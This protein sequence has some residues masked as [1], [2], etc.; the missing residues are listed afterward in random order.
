MENSRPESIKIPVDVATNYKLVRQRDNLS[1]MGVIK[2]V[3]WNKD[4]G[5]KALHEKPEV[6][7]SCIVNPN[8]ISYTWLT[9][10][11]TEL[12]SETEFRTENSHYKIE[13]IDES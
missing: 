1:K 5:F 2:W 7:Y 12:I 9:T 11:I 3:E 10:T 8:R 4:G 13:E 6:G